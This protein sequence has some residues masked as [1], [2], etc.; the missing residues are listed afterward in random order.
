MS[1][2]L[3][4]IILIIVYTYP[5]ILIALIFV[6]R[7]RS[8]RNGKTEIKRKEIYEKLEGDDTPYGIWKRKMASDAESFARLTL[9]RDLIFVLFCLLLEIIPFFDVI[10]RI[11]K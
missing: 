10:E 5:L 7:I 9:C 11:T 4:V 3:P 8:K 6:N 2:V 1:N